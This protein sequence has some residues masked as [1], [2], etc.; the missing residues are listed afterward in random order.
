[1]AKTG[2]ESGPTVE[3]NGSTV[4]SED[5]GQGGAGEPVHVLI[6]DDHQLFRTG[7]SELLEQEGLKVVGAVGDG[8][9]ALELVAQCAPDVVLMDLEMPGLSGLEVTRRI[10]EIAPRTRVVVL[11]ID[12][13]EQ[14]VVDA[15]AAGACGYLLKGTSLPSL[16]A[17]I[18]AAVAGESLI[19]AAVGVKLFERL[20]ADDRRTAAEQ[21]VYSDLSGR[22]LEILKLL[23]SGMRNADIAQALFISPHTVRT[24]ISN[25]LA[26]LHISN[27]IEATVYAIRNRLV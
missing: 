27:R 19:S 21:R 11:T 5:S 8:A 12:A 15:I 9:S 20:R 17:G 26:K 2:G 10:A 16:V 3:A 18:K 6:V 1:V 7:L 23:A 25:I 24:H 4:E 22:E 13:D 14:S